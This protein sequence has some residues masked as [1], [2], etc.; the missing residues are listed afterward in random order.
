MRIYFYFTFF[1]LLCTETLS[2]QNNFDDR[3]TEIETAIYEGKYQASF[4]SSQTLLKE[5][6]GQ[7]KFKVLLLNSKIAIELNKF[8]QAD[9]LLILAEASN[10][11][12]MLVQSLN[13]SLYSSILQED[14]AKAEE[15]GRKISNYKKILQ[16]NPSIKADFLEYAG[17]LKVEQEIYEAAEKHYTQAI[18]LRKKNPSNSQLYLGRLNY[19]FARIAI[20]KSQFALAERFLSTSDRL[21]KRLGTQHPDYAF[22]K[23][24]QGW[25]YSKKAKYR[26]AKIA[27][28]QAIEIRRTTL[29]DGHLKLAES[30]IN[31]GAVLQKEGNYEKAEGYFLK[32][33]SIF[34]NKNQQLQEGIALQHL[35]ILA[36]T[37]AG[38]DKA[39]IYLEQSAAL[40][41]SSPKIRFYTNT[42]NTLAIVYELLD[43]SSKSES[44]YLNLK[45]LWL[46]KRGKNNAVYPVIISNLG[47]YYD[48]NGDAEKALPLYEE[49]AELFKSIY[50][51]EDRNYAAIL[52]NL[53]YLYESIGEFDKAE[54]NYLKMEKIDEAVLGSTHPDYLYSLYNIAK[55]YRKTGNQTA[56][57][58]YFQ[59]ANKGQLELIHNYYAGFDEATRIEYLKEVQIGFNELYSHLADGAADIRLLNDAQQISLSTKG[60]ALDYNRWNANTALA[61]TDSLTK[62]FYK[63]WQQK[64]KALTAAYSLSQKERAAIGINLKQ[65]K[66][67]TTLAEKQLVRAAKKSGQAILLHQKIQATSV[68]TALKAQE[69]AIDFIRF[70]YYPTDAEVSDTI[71]Y[72]ALLTRQ[73]QVKSQFVRLCTE[74]ELQEILAV[75]AQFGAGYAKYP[76][77]GEAL[78]QLVWQPL[79]RYLDNVETVHL[80]PT[81]LLHQVAYSSLPKEEQPLLN[82][83]QL[84]Y[85]GNLRDFVQ[86]EKIDIDHHIALV[87]GAIFDMDSTQLKQIADSTTPIVFD[88]NTATSPTIAANLHSRAIANDSTRN[89]IE[90]NYLAG[91]KQE[92]ENINQQFKRKNWRVQIFTDFHATEDNIKNL[93]GPTAPNILHLATHGFFFNPFEKATQNTSDESLRERI[94]TAD[95]PLL[96]SGL[97]FSG[98]NHFWKGGQRIPNIE[99]GVLT[100]LEIA[101]LNLW[102]TQLVVLSACET[103]L[104]DTESS[105]GVFGLQRAFKAAGVEQLLISLWKIPDAQ[106]AALMQSFYQYFLEGFTPEVALRKA[107]LEMSE[108]YDAFYWAGFVLL[109]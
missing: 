105:E 106:T 17:L 85:Y 104:G 86:A 89:A 38:Y 44:I 91:T 52:N 29:N 64:K 87:G 88:A 101:N 74:K 18:N 92:V 102:N 9:S 98:V 93:E 5:T 78:Y 2:A 50:G 81:G 16:K 67:Q 32:A 107:Q 56:T 60:L 47:E 103:G 77:I 59:K 100:A 15:I 80:S 12:R 94:I 70:K 62:A 27:L 46:T 109:H 108:Q 35:G 63:E 42:M 68:R 71:L 4:L 14:Y 51:E 10:N 43:Q 37:L 36:Y 73:D 26:E 69:V 30:Y 7:D 58:N 57:I 34:E 25:L 83:Y 72:Y 20:E 13:L 61:A 45:S 79:E 75:S 76:E 66:E 95:S 3:L 24:Y 31:L 65:L 21:L 48:F 55:L 8:K 39:A 97:V 40:L 99:D 90:F 54:V 82:Q 19:R 22:V 11:K 1:W 96:R 84:K 28:A 6:N 53:A 23:D 49:A 41:E 33:K